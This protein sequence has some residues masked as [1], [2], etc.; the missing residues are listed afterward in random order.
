MSR[1]AYVSDSSHIVVTPLIRLIK[2]IVF[3]S[4]SDEC[5]VTACCSNIWP[6]KSLTSALYLTI[7]WRKATIAASVMVVKQ[8]CTTLAFSKDFLSLCVSD[9]GVVGVWAAVGV[10]SC[11]MDGEIRNIH[12]ANVQKAGI[13]LKDL[14]S[15]ETPCFYAGQRSW[16]GSRSCW[17]CSTSTV[18][19]CSQ[20]NTRSSR[21]ISRSCS[22][23]RRTAVTLQPW[24]QL[25]RRMSSSVSKAEELGKT[26]FSKAKPDER[27]IIPCVLRSSSDRYQS[28][29]KLQSQLAKLIIT[30][31]NYA[32]STW[33]ANFFFILVCCKPSNKLL[34]F[35]VFE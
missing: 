18:P 7:R 1:S 31:I 25:W 23:V 2:L 32:N 6:R 12:R 5:C 30:R 17:R 11:R 33:N 10:Y 14:P 19:R 20:A 22:F 24:I 16:R 15:V 3:E 8:Y 34:F 35:I 29:T 26:V 27:A 28:E 13:Y 4:M 21:R 9:S